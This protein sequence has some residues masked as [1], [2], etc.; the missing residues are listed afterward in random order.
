MLS[1]SLEIL[2]DRMEQGERVCKDENGEE[3]REREEREEE[4]TTWCGCVSKQASKQ[5]SN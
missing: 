5:A 4:I 1:W 2:E 3:E